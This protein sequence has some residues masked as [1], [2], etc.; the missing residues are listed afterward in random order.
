[1]LYPQNG[2]GIVAIDFVTSLHHMYKDK[3]NNT[4]WSRRQGPSTHPFCRL[5]I[6]TFST[7]E[8]DIT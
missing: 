2:D 7:G 1:M 5:E 3:N 4:T 6:P 8:T